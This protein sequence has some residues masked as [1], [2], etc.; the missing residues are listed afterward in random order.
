MLVFD[1]VVKVIIT[2]I[3][4]CHYM[5][6]GKSLF[7]A[8]GVVQRELVRGGPETAE[9]G[10]GQVSR[11]GLRKPWSRYFSL[12][13]SLSVCLSLS[14]SLSVFLSLSLTLSCLSSLCNQGVICLPRPFL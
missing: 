9:A 6:T 10:T 12:S 1:V 2:C 7:A 3:S 4:L 13:L 5:Y 11:R 8:D 14:V